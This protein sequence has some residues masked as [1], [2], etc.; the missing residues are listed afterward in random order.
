[1]VAPSGMCV[2]CGRDLGVEPHF[3]TIPP[4]GEHVACRDWTRH[5]WPSR[6]E[7]LGRRLT[8]RAEALQHALELAT[9]LGRYLVE[10]R[11]V[12]PD[13]AAETVLEVGRRRRELR[14][15]ME[16]AGVSS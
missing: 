3:I 11:E 6:L 7:Q 1:M 16:H 13:G 12:W 15:A 8:K 10:R 9:Q 4:D 5:P 14:V 2:T